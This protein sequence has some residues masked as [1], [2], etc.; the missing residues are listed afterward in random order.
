MYK[1]NIE[2]NKSIKKH[3]SWKVDTIT[4]VFFSPTNIDELANFLNNNNEQ[5]LFLGLGSNLLI[6]NAVF[7]GVIINTKQLKTINYDDGYI[8]AQCGVSLAKLARFSVANNLY[9]LEFLSAIPGSVGGALTMNAGCFNSEIWQWVD[10]VDT[11]DNNGI[12]HTRY[13]EDFSIDYRCVVAKYDTEYF[14][15][16]RLKPDIV[17]KYPSIKQ[18]LQKRQ[19][20]QPN[21]LH[22]CGSVFVNPVGHYAG[23]LIERANLK[24]FCIGDAC[25]SEQHANFI[26]NTNNANAVDIE[27]LIKYIQKTIKYK[28]NIEL[29]T[30]VKII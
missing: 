26:I 8:V 17:N 28:F 25:I 16:A 4:K 10:N 9:G 30:E 13:K 15:S 7:D 23:E 24:G 18:L 12:I 22:S 6:K 11:I 19:Q 2:H 21:S 5:I 29:T 14:I 1:L 27:K 3:L 20:T